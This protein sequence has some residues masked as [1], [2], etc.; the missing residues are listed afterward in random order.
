MLSIGFRLEI[1]VNILDKVLHPSGTQSGTGYD[2][3]AI[4]GSTQGTAK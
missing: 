2:L 1:D 4:T 3:N